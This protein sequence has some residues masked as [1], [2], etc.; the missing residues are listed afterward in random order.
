MREKG[1]YFNF[2][3]LIAALASILLLFMPYARINDSNGTTFTIIGSNVGVGIMI[4]ILTVTGFVFSF[5]AEKGFDLVA[6]FW[7]TAPDGA[8]PQAA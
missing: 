2:G 6:N 7:G 8:A 3:F 5:I 4:F 1:V